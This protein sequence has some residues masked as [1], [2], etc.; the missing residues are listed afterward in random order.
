MHRTYRGS[1]GALGTSLP[2][3]RQVFYSASSMPGGENVASMNGSFSHHL[4]NRGDAGSDLLQ[5]AFSK[6]DHSFFFGLLPYLCR[7]CTIEDQILNRR[8]NFHYFEKAHPALVTAVIAPLAA[9]SLIDSDV[10]GQRGRETNVN[11]R[12]DRSFYLLLALF[13]NHPH[14][15]LGT[16]QVH[17]IGNQERLDPHVQQTTHG[18]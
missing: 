16:D 11:Q 7:T 9:G 5:A 8:G 2:L 3:H 18:R 13:T 15:T 6:G 12:L 17:R 10:L 1:T 14:Q 4:I